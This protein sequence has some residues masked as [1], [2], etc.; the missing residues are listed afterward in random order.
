LKYGPLVPL[1]EHRFPGYGQL[2]RGDIV[3]FKSPED[4]KKHFVKRFIAFPGETVEIKGGDVYINEEIVAQSEIRNL[5]YYNKGDYGARGQKIRVP[6][7]SYFVL[8][9]NSSSSMDSR[10]FGFVPETFLVGKAEF[11]YWPLHR[12]RVLK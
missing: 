10:F 12:M 2:H 4:P 6:E 11:I 7:D 1:T 9:D 8:G 5:Y 3:V